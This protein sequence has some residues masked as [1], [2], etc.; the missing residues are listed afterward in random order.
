[1]ILVSSCLLGVYAK[2]DGTMTNQNECLMKY[3]HLGK[4]IPVCPEQLGGLCTPRKPVELIGGSGC[5][6][7]CGSAKAE[8][9]LREDVTEQ[10]RRGAEETLRLTRIF[11]VR[12]AILKER[13]PSCGVHKIYDGEFSH[14]LK[15]GS[16]V[17]AELLRQ[18]GIE[19]YSEED[20]SE[21]LLRRLLDL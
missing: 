10:F 16:G 13:S 11:P 1:M 20:L 14:V 5:D 9:S 21:E 17:T 2:Y 6:V 3:C 18:N 12:A 15:E 8:N 7:L 19:I 4:Y